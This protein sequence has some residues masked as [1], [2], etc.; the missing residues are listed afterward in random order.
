MV[1]AEGAADERGYR[2]HGEDGRCGR[3]KLRCMALKAGLGVTKAPGSGW[4]AGNLAVQAK[5][6][7]IK[8][9]G[10]GVTRRMAWVAGQQDSRRVLPYG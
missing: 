10:G 9:L 4:D 6:K 2:I 7:K 1:V 5:D 8:F 3:D